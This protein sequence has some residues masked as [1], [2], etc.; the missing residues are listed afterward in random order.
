MS[1]NSM[2]KFDQTESILPLHEDWVQV[3]A[4]YT[5]VL[6]KQKDICGLV[7]RVMGTGKDTTSLSVG[8]VVVT[9]A[10]P[11]PALILRAD[12]CL[13]VKNLGVIHES[14]AFWAFVLA[15]IPAF[16]LSE[17]EIGEQV[18]VLSNN[19]VGQM[20]ANVAL[21]AGAGSCVV[22]DSTYVDAADPA[23]AFELPQGIRRVKDLSALD[24]LLPN[25]SVDL[26]IDASSDSNHLQSIFERVRNLGRVLTVGQYSPS[27]IDFNIYPDL[28]KRSLKF[29]NYRLPT[30]MEEFSLDDKNHSHQ[31][32]RSLDFVRHLFETGRLRPST[33][34]ITKIKTPTEDKLVHALQDMGSSALLI[35]W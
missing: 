30:T 18:L 16:R 33:W 19:L 34:S 17:I 23:M 15:L 25:L 21:L 1:S 22:V 3:E 32:N 13:K 9:F 24:T 6:P 26:L 35:E 12:S 5:V 11:K 2:A 14:M 29:L 31:I 27:Q 7:G 4:V 10:H 20:I 28:H 8:D